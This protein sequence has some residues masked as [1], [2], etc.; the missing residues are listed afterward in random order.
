MVQH[1]THV[2]VPLTVEDI[3]VVAFVFHSI[4]VF[5]HSLYFTLFPKL[6]SKNVIGFYSNN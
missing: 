3:M 4:D 2:S 5:S 1:N 6:I